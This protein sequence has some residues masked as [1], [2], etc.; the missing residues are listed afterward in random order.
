MYFKL[1]YI[2]ICPILMLQ[3]FWTPEEEISSFIVPSLQILRNILKIR[4]ISKA[5]KFFGYLPIGIKWKPT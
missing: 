5:L 1:A 3:L 2:Y 4:N